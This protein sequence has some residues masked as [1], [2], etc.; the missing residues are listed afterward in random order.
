MDPCPLGLRVMLTVAHRGVLDSFKYQ[1]LSHQIH[2]ISREANVEYDLSV[3]LWA[4]VIGLA[5]ILVGSVR[6]DSGWVRPVVYHWYVIRGV[7][8]R[9]SCKG[10][11]VDWRRET[12]HNARIPWFRLRA[13][14]H[15]DVDSTQHMP[16]STLLWPAGTE[17]LQVPGVVE[18]WLLRLVQERA[19][20]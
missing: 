16:Q 11:A 6:L 10:D 12:G 13:S 17:P 14:D 1:A 8:V 19:R 20:L 18:C 7:Q 5:W 15:W 4:V 9:G 2:E 3:F